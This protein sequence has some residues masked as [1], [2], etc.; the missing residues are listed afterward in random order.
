MIN[1]I[2]EIAQL[3]WETW[4]SVLADKVPKA[5]AEIWEDVQSSLINCLTRWITGLFSS[6]SAAVAR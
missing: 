4:R 2:R 3:V 6:P 1:M 5:V